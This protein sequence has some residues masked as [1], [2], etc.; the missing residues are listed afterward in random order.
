MM[1]ND[2]E[3]NLIMFACETNLRVLCE[4]DT[5]F[6]DGTFKYSAKHFLQFFT[7][8]GIRSGH[9]IPL[10]FFLLNSKSCTAYEHCF[11]TLRNECFKLNLSFQ[12]RVVFTDFEQAIHASLRAVW[13]EVNIKGCRFHLAQAWWRQIQALRLSSEYK[14]KTDVGRFLSHIFGLPMLNKEAV[15][16]CFLDDFM[17]NMP[18]DERV[19]KLMDYLTDY[20]IDSQSSF[21]P[22]MWADMTSSAVRTT[23]A[24]ESFHSRFNNSFYCPHPDIFTFLE[25]LKNFQIDTN[26]AIRTSQDVERRLRPVDKRRIAYIED[27]IR[28]Y[29]ANEIERFHFIKIMAVSYKPII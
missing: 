7:L 19:I 10:A 12:P 2:S 15:E 29:V 26:I 27:T 18:D 8:H 23:N 25:A 17:A 4:L 20:Y 21:P 9:Y 1:V 11:R 24:C 3:N 5:F 14:N 16:D 22:E 28:K 13:P 6:V